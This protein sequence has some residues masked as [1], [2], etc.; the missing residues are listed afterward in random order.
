MAAVYSW[1]ES[2]PMMSCDDRLRVSSGWSRSRFW[3]TVT[4]CV[5]Y[6]TKMCS[7]EIKVLLLPSLWYLQSL[8]YIGKKLA[9]IGYCVKGY[10][11]LYIAMNDLEKWS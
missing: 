6:T 9:N 4:L 7:F 5:L 1:G 10:T 2:M 8:L 3:S 11:C